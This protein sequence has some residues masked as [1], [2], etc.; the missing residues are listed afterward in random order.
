MYKCVSFLSPVEKKKMAGEGD[1]GREAEEEEEE[2]EVAALSLFTFISD[3][4]C[5]EIQSS[6]YRPASLAQ[7]VERS[8]RKGEVMRSKLIGGTVFF[9]GADERGRRGT[10]RG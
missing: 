10:R 6:H 5:L 1:G 4:K 2:E 9:L 3:Y 7:L 8:L